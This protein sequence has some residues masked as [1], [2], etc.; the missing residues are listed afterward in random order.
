MWFVD[1]V[2]EYQTFQLV[3]YIIIFMLVE[4]QKWGNVN[5][6]EEKKN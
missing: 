2:S 6:Y 3:L 4:E 5:K 1:V